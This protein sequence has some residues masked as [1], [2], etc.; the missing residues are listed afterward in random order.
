MRYIEEAAHSTPIQLHFSTRL[1]LQYNWVF[2]ANALSS[3][4]MMARPGPSSLQR[5]LRFNNLLLNGDSLED[6]DLNG[7]NVTETEMDEPSSDGEEDTFH[8]AN[9]E[10][11]EFRKLI[12]TSSSARKMGNKGSVTFR[13]DT[14]TISSSKSKSFP[15]SRRKDGVGAEPTGERDDEPTIRQ[16]DEEGESIERSEGTPTS[17]STAGKQFS[18]AIP[19]DDKQD[20]RVV[21]KAGPVTSEDGMHLPTSSEFDLKTEQPMPMPIFSTDVIIAV[22]AS[23]ISALD[24][25]VRRGFDGRAPTMSEYTPGCDVVGTV[26]KCGQ[27]VFLSGISEGERVACITRYGG[28]ARY[29]RVPVSCCIKTRLDIDSSEASGVL[30]PYF[31]A[32]QILQA[33]VSPPSRYKAPLKGKQILV[34]ENTGIVGLAMASL[35]KVGGAKKAFIV[36]PQEH[37]EQIKSLGAVPLS[38]SIDGWARTIREKVDILVD[39]G[40]VTGEVQR[41]FLK[42]SGKLVRLALPP[43]PPPA[44]S[45]PSLMPAP[46]RN[47][48]SVVHMAC[49][50]NSAS[51]YDVFYSIERNQA[52][53]KSDL[54]HIFHLL[55]LRRIRPRIDKFVLLQDVGQCHREL[56][57]FQQEGA[58]VC[59]PWRRG[60][61]D[62]MIYRT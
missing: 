60:G 61:I 2:P 36:C 16:V 55:A 17:T 52:L 51:L 54:M 1:G 49:I 33:G 43:V 30:L 3:F 44:E 28:N 42:T 46:I 62:S 14:K 48:C 11:I 32:F 56:E 47:F 13:G 15:S 7:E 37:H 35:C 39:A 59:E 23:S 25:A 10:Y 58:I 22:E 34:G 45:K 6:V 9:T 4:I 41:M 20:I 50:A 18:F 26:V 31:M 8:H 21:C 5:A 57:K 24:C 40:K 27:E 19:E 12:Q 53:Y 29:I 38:E